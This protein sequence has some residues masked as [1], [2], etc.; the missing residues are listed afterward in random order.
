MKKWKDRKDCKI[1]LM[2]Q[3]LTTSDD[4]RYY[5]YRIVPSELP[6]FQRIFRNPWYCAYKFSEYS[7]S[8]NYRCY[9]FSVDDYYK[10]IEPLRTYGDAVSFISEQYDKVEAHKKEMIEKHRI[11]P[12]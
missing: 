4:L 1:E 12:N 6:F 10:Y 8:G 3:T 5:W 9:A 7:L 2:Y 11:W